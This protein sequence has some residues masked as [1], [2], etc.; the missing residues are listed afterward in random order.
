[1]KKGAM[2]SLPAIYSDP[3]KTRLTADV[4]KAGEQGTEINFDLKAK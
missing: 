1:M 4:S 3:E 2:E